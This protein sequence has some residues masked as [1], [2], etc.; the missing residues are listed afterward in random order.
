MLDFK[1]NSPRRFLNEFVSLA[2]P[3][4]APRAPADRRAAKPGATPAPGVARKRRRH[5]NLHAGNAAPLTW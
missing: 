5:D 2:E 3:G 4:L 1:V